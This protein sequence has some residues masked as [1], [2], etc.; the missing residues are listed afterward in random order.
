[1]TKPEAHTILNTA[2]AGGLIP[3]ALI[4]EALQTTGDLDEYRQEAVTVETMHAHM[5]CQDF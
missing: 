4:T 2:R 5:M 1:M 3:T